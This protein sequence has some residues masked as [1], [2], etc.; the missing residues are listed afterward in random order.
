MFA[1]DRI[2]DIK[3]ELDE[4]DWDEIRVQAR[5]FGQALGKTLTPKPYSYVKGNI[6]I[7]G[8]EIKDVGIRK[9]G[10]LGSLNSERPSLKI[11][12]HEYKKDQAPVEGLDRLTLNNNNQDASRVCTYLSFKLFRDSGTVA[13]RCGFAKVTVNGKYLGIYS[14]IEAIKPEFLKYGYGDDSGAVFEGTVCD[15]FPGWTQ[16]FEPKNKAA[17]PEHIDAVTKIFGPDD[18]DIEELRKVVDVEAFINFWAMESLMGFWDGYCSNQNNYYIYRHPKNEK[19][20][21]IPWGTDS[22]FSE[23]SPIPPYRIVPR[24]VHGKAIIP[25]RLYNY[26]ETQKKYIETLKK[27]LDE[28]WKEDELLA[29]FDRL[30][31]LLEPHITKD[32][33]SFSRVMN[34]YRGFVKKRR[35][36]LMAELEDGPPKL[37][38][39]ERQPVYVKNSG[40]AKIKFSTKWYDREPKDTKG[41]GKATLEIMVDGKELELK[42]VGVYAKRDD[43]NKENASIIIQ[44]IR[45]SNKKRIIIGASIPRTSFKSGEKDVSAGGMMFQL[46]AFGFMGA[47]T[48]MMFGTIS[49]DEA[50]LEDGGVV[51]GSLEMSIA[52]FNMGEDGKK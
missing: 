13:P 18:F 47:K 1:D 35:K 33:R 23:T 17:K 19:F 14:N 44:G 40:L 39:K 22:S 25:N 21:F 31:K 9:K 7:D 50:S 12:F 11:K 51:E 24:S 16:K 41:V 34:R 45:T 36:S 46:G 32:N 5:N 15:F 48:K 29:E 20:Y 2:T 26:D 10:F 43:R 6:T 52:Q 42:D 28:H 27:F 30:E 3:I 49:L 8:V 37:R 38:S 4:K